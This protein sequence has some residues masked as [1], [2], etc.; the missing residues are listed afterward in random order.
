MENFL[1]QFDLSGIILGL[2]AVSVAL[3]LYFLVMIIVL[4][5]RIIKQNKKPIEALVKDQ[6]ISPEAEL[7]R[8]EVWQRLADQAQSED[9]NRVK[10]AII[11]ADQILDSLLVKK[12]I[13]GDDMGERLRQLDKNQ[14]A[15]L[16]AVWQAHKARNRI[17]HEADFRINNQ[18]A[19]AIIEIFQKAVQDLA[20]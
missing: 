8:D 15:N 1:S 14:L 4:A 11:E 18:Q 19:K 6:T 20:G 3:S 10:M 16:E 17:A 7:S 2:K 13:K 9:E 12:G 5:S